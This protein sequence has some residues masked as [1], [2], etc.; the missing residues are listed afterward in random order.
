MTPAKGN[1]GNEGP[2]FDCQAGQV[3]RGSRQSVSRPRLWDMMHKPVPTTTAQRD[4]AATSD[5]EF[6]HECDSVAGPPGA[7]TDAE[8]EDQETLRRR[9][10]MDDDQGCD[11]TPASDEG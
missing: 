9:R 10:D 1:A 4:E 2:R 11:S 6:D 5:H 3:L 8:A 7:C